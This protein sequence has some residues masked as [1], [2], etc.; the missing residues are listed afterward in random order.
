[1]K[2]L[3]PCL[4]L[5]TLALA[6]CPGGGA[7]PPDVILVTL[8]TTRPDFLGCYGS[9]NATPHLDRLAREGVLFER[10][11]STSAVTPVS[12]ASILTGL[13]PYQ[14]GLRVLAAPDRKSVV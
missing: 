10:S 7:A 13:T 8:D 2:S 3:P 14:H 11:Y 6:S 5:L 4:T 9:E 1:M 12:H